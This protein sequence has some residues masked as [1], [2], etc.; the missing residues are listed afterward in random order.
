[1]ENALIENDSVRLFLVINA[2][3]RLKLVERCLY[4]TGKHKT[5]CASFV[6]TYRNYATGQ[7][8]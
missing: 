3:S 2:I 1:M 4:Q 8:E 7:F 5:T 6:L